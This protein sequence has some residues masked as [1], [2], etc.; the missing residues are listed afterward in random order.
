MSG[1]HHNRNEDYFKLLGT[2][3]FVRMVSITLPQVG[4]THCVFLAW[5]YFLFFLLIIFGI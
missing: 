2:V 5:G 4:L 1:H 3:Q